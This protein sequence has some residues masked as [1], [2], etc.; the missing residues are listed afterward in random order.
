MSLSKNRNGLLLS[1][2]TQ[3]NFNKKI[4]DIN[5]NTRNNLIEWIIIII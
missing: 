5:I 2:N 3:K 4:N 1:I